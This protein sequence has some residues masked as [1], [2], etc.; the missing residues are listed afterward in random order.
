MLE[1]KEVIKRFCDLSGKVMKDRFSFDYPSDCF[2][3][4][5]PEGLSG[6]CYSEKILDFI[7][8]AVNEKLSREGMK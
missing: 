3:G 2:C 6:F 1:K 4:E 8:E 7:T 5:V